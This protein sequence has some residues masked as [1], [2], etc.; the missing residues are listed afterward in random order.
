MLDNIAVRN[1]T[2]FIK[3]FSRYLITE[4]TLARVTS[5]SKKGLHYYY[6]EY[7]LLHTTLLIIT[8]RMGE[9]DRDLDD[10]NVK[11]LL[12]RRD[13]EAQP[14]AQCCVIRNKNCIT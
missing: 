8:P 7:T 4:H 5:Q 6:N 2:L 13:E 9:P 12:I 1:S 14:S 3:I 11:Q 10:A